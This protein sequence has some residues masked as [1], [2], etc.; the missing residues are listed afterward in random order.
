MTRK[1]P[2]LH[3]ICVR[4]ESF[5]IFGQSS[6]GKT[7]I[8]SMITGALSKSSGNVWIG[9]YSLTHDLST[10]HTLIGYCPQVIR[11]R[12]RRDFLLR[13]CYKS[14]F[15]GLLEDLTGY[16]TMRIIAMLRGYPDR[17][18]NY[19]IHRLAEEFYF[20]K[21]LHKAIKKYSGGTKR[22]LSVALTLIGNTAIVVLGR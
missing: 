14:Q 9:G 10:V 17:R 16:Q 4:Y 19:V 18:I 7:T 3:N 1:L 2:T 5:G 20:T 12:F 21:H 15:K 6:A 22:K 8:V 11:P 13:N